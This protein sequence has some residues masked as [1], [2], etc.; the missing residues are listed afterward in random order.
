[1]SLSKTNSKFPAKI[2]ALKGNVDRLYT[3]TDDKWKRY[4]IGTFNTK[5]E[6]EKVRS[7]VKSKG[8]G[9]AYIVEEDAMGLIETIF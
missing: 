1:M 5:A 8:F 2:N 9:S 7:Y 3:K 6:A 4:R